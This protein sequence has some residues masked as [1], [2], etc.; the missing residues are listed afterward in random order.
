MTS[1]P[2]TSRLAPRLAR[3]D[4]DGT[5]GSSASTWPGGW[6]CWGCSRPTCGRARGSTSGSSTA[7]RPSSSRRWPGSRSASRRAGPGPWRGA[8]GAP[9]WAR[10]PSGPCCSSC[11]GTLLQAWNGYVLVILPYYGGCSSWLLLVLFAPRPV[12]LATAAVV[13]VVAPW[14]ASLVPVTNLGGT[15]RDRPRRPRRRRAARGL[16]PGARAGCPSCSSGWWRPERPAAAPHP[17]RAARRRRRRRGRRL[18]RP[19]PPPARATSRPSTP[20]TTRACPRRSSAAAASRRRSIGLLLLVTS[21]DGA[22]GRAA[23]VAL[24]PLSATGAQPLTVYSAHLLL[25]APLF[26]AYRLQG[27]S[28]GCRSAGSSPPCC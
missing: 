13:T 15:T 8:D 16:V 23:R 4:G 10:S 11:C 1:V 25:T 6:R 26:T 17:A 12:L 20:P 18:R 7:G 28:T 19:L 9:S 21:P 14:L 24:R 2:G 22:A 5:R 3:P 27:G